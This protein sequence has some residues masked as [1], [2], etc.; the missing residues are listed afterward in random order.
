[1]YRYV[2]AEDGGRETAVKIDE[3]LSWLLCIY[4]SG[5]VF[6]LV[7][8]DGGNVKFGLSS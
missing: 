3:A 5:C 1:M 4:S 2:R 7:N 6:T 8:K